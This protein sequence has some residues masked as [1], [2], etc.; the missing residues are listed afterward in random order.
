MTMGFRAQYS[1]K[2]TALA[3]PE[4]GLKEL[5]QAFD[6]RMEL[7]QTML[8]TAVVQDVTGSSPVTHARS[9]NPI[10]PKKVQTPTAT[11][12]APAG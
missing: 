12:Y 3:E 4:P 10:T 9:S 7:H 6:L 1:S 5:Y 2:N 11:G 8:P